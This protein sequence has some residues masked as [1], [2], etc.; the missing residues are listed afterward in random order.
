MR[1]VKRITIEMGIQD[2]EVKGIIKPLIN[3]IIDN[4]LI[5]EYGKRNGITVT[6]QELSVAVAEI[7]GDYPERV[8]QDVLLQRYIDFEDWK[9]VLRQQL[10]LKKIITSAT[11]SIPPITFPEIKVYFDTHRGD[12]RYDKMVKLQQIVTRSKEEAET[13]SKMLAQGQDMNALARQYSIAPEA[14]DGGV[15]GWI[16]MG[17]L[18]K[19]MERAIIL[20]PVGKKSPI[21]K[22]PYGY[23]IF[24][25]LALRSEGQKTLREAMAE[26]ETKL[27]QEK[28]DIFYRDWLRELRGVFPVMVNQHIYQTL[29]LS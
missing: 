24:E 5:L 6:E 20:L 8:F 17:E 25:V 23:H 10:L 27:Y 7:K 14:K 19:S 22:T 26:I 12:Y 28:E 13:I 3:K 15:M 29:E 11:A 4:Y 9:T 18:E 16:N 1:D 2:Q 21:V